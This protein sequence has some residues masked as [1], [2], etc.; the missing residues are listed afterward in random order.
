VQ[1]D[2]PVN[3]DRMWLVVWNARHGKLQR[4]EYDQI[5]C[6]VD[7]IVFNRNDYA[8]ALLER[9]QE[10]GTW[11]NSAECAETMENQIELPCTYGEA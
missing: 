1:I 4:T 7:L 8:R 10:T 6:H 11:E 3:R 9:L 5:G 2:T